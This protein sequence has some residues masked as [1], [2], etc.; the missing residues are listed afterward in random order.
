VKTFGEELWTT[1]AQ[2]VY[3]Q[4][5]PGQEWPKGWRFKGV[6]NIPDAFG[7]TVYDEKLVEICLKALEDNPDSLIDTVI[8]ELVHVIH[9]HGLKH[10]P[11]F[12]AL[13]R[14]AKKRRKSF[15]TKKE[16]KR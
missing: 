7:M 10:G 4:A 9:G 15:L 1:Y 6:A 8:H 5:F 2:V 13:L 3:S 16:K 12:Y 11:R 14:E